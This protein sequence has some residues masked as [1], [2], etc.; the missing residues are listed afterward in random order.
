MIFKNQN[1]IKGFARNT[2]LDFY[3]SKYSFRKNNNEGIDN[4]IKEI[5]I[6]TTSAHYLSWKSPSEITNSIITI[7][8]IN[9]L[10]KADKLG[11]I[12]QFCSIVL[13]KHVVI[14][15]QGK[16]EIKD[17]EFVLRKLSEFEIHSVLVICDFAEEYYTDHFGELI[18]GLTINKRLIV[19]NSPFE[20]N[21]EDTM[22]FTQKNDLYSTQKTELEIKPSLTL[23]SESLLHNVYFNRKLFIGPNG[24]IKNAPECED[25]FGCIQD[26]NS[27]EQLKEIIHTPEFQK[28]WFVHKEILDVCKDCEFRHM[29][30][31]NRL[32]Y[33]RS[34]KEW[35]HKIECN[36]NPYIAKWESEKGYKTLEECGVISN[37]NGF[38][39][40]H[41]KIAK[42]NAELWSEV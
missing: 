11:L 18:M 17:I 32:P 5:N 6:D 24:E 16:L 42:I 29:C 2:Y 33:K 34:E 37:E 31:D 30:V 41:D 7:S 19:M 23:F 35:Y 12:L 38:T 21:F 20:K 8:K 36:Y 10:Y 15:I 9:E 28:Y 27:A 39:I 1:I 14:R 22:F 13:C 3:N 26:L 25:S 40:D 4:V